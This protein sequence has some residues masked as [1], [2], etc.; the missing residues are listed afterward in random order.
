MVTP[1]IKYTFLVYH[2][3]IEA[4][5]EKL[6]GLGVVDVSV[7]G[8]EYSD[9][10]RSALTS[11]NEYKNILDKAE[12]FKTATTEFTDENMH[13][14]LP[15]DT[16]DDIR[17]AYSEMVET[18]EKL[19]VL[20][21]K[22]TSEIREVSVWG[23]FDYS[24]ISQL[25]KQGVIIYFYMVS[26]KSFKQEWLDKYNIEVISADK[27]YVNFVLINVNAE[28][29]PDF[30]GATPIKQPKHD[31]FTLKGEL[32]K[33]KEELKSLDEVLFRIYGNS[34]IIH[35]EIE[36]LQY[37][38]KESLIKSTNYTAA[39]NRLYVIEGWT[40]ES[41]CEL[42]DAEYESEENVAVIKDKPTFEDN[43]PILLKN[44]KFAKMCEMVSG[45]Y[46]MPSYHELDLTPFFA[47]FFVL[48]VGFCFGDVGYAILLFIGALT[49]NIVVKNKAI[50][51]ITSLI[52]WCCF[53]AIIMGSLTGTFFGIDLGKM[54]MFKNIKFLGQMD[55]F[56]L[57]LGI[58]LFQI[59]YA[60]FV[61]AYARI[62]YQGFK[63]A[64]STL[65][66]AFA[67]IVSGAAFVL[68]EMGIQFSMQSVAYKII[69]GVLLLLNILFFDASKK[70]L[71][72]NFG[73][74]TW[75]LYNGVTGLLGDVLSY[76]RLFALGLSSGII[77]SVF[78]DLA[79]GMSGDVPVLKYIIMALILIIGH[80][81]NIFMSAIGSFVHPL[82]LTFV[83]FYKNAGFEGGGREYAPFKKEEEK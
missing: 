35:D 72:S 43:P 25:K 79:V 31:A 68:P 57:A 75:E 30:D 48:F 58:G 2:Q 69:I 3:S 10:Q 7:S 45:L 13:V 23:A 46:S 76:I 53:A 24:I 18:K 17:K 47:P 60:M 29:L 37:L 40:P 71:L 66:W 11:I 83:E 27:H 67:I 19:T 20:K 8:A 56:S 49:A 9:E 28:Q 70:N 33:V 34:R 64:I 6:G 54:E 1:M 39:D 55:M 73:I 32:R 38:L 61:K 59:L 82:R 52:M 50:R 14:T 4:F 74:G 81:I 36:R 16:A 63:Y 78:N 26:A 42:V 41:K 65:S 5:I 44:N 77:A 21:S 15:F 80:G 12:H 22:L 62:K 51:P